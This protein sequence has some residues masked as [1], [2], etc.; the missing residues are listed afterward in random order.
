MSGGTDTYQSRYVQ[1]PLLLREGQ[2]NN[3]TNNRHVIETV[4]G[5]ANVRILFSS[6]ET[7][8]IR[9]AV[10]SALTVSYEQRIQEQLKQL[11]ASLEPS[12]PA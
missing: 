9:E 5:T 2:M 6:E 1:P 7:H 12:I 11:C 8:G 10:I 4:V 3:N